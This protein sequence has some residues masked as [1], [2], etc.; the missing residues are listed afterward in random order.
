VGQQ[1]MGILQLVSTNFLACGQVTFHLVPN[2]GA[3]A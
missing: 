1:Y 3:L 2:I